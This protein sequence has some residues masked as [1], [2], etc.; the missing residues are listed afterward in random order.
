MSASPSAHPQHVFKL[1]QIISRNQ[2]LVKNREAEKVLWMHNVA[3]P[4][5]AVTPC[6]EDGLGRRQTHALNFNMLDF[7]M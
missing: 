4:A 1:V 7:Y 3:D 2:H 5:Q 6:Q